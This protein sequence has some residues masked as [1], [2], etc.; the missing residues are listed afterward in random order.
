MAKKN[1]ASLMDGIIGDDSIRQNQESAIPKTSETS[2]SSN[3]SELSGADKTGVQPTQR[4]K[5]GRPP[6]SAADRLEEVRATIIVEPDVLKKIKYISLIEGSMIKEVMNEA[7][8]SYITAWEAA[9][10]KIRL[11]QKRNQN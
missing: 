10:G 9:N 1:L 2:D 5:P 8:L 3:N 4:R 11:P 7:F 6:K